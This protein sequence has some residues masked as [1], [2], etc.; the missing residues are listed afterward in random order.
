M[1]RSSFEGFIED[2]QETTTTVV[3]RIVEGGFDTSPPSPPAWIVTI[4]EPEN[5]ESATAALDRVKNSDDGVYA[6]IESDGLFGFQSDHGDGLLIK[7]KKVLAEEAGFEARDYERLAKLNHE[8]AKAQHLALSK[9]VIKLQ[10][11]QGLLRDQHERVS[12]KL[13]GHP[14]DST[15]HT[16]YEQQLAFI[17][18]LLAEAEA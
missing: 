14:F 5:R 1:P 3:V 4:E 17:A 16:L 8:W 12:R 15:A 11:I 13:E 7:G 2:I 18:R 6:W 10:R 9:Q